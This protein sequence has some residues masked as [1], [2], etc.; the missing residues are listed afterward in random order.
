MKK[1]FLALIFFITPII[2]NS[3]TFNELKII[4]SVNDF[5]KIMIENNFQ[6]YKYEGEGKDVDFNKDIVVF[7]KIEGKNGGGV[8]YAIFWQYEGVVFNWALK[9]NKTTKLDFDENGKK[10]KEYGDYTDI[11]DSVKKECKYLEI[12]NVN[13]KDYVCYI[14]DGNMKYGFCIDKNGTANFVNISE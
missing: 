10:I 4:K 7:K 14:C 3:Q 9:F 11:V 1:I 12:L 13:E 5:K 2:S 8:K 6:S